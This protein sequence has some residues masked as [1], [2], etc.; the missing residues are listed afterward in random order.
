MIE[1]AQLACAKTRFFATSSSSSSIYRTTFHYYP[2]YDTGRVLAPKFTHEK[3]LID[4]I[5]VGRG[6][7]NVICNEGNWKVL[8]TA[9]RN[10]T[11]PCNYIVCSQTDAGEGK[12]QILR[13]REGEDDATPRNRTIFLVHTHTL[14]AARTR[15]KK[16]H[17]E[18]KCI[19]LGRE[20][21]Q[22]SREMSLSTSKR[23]S[24]AETA[25][26]NNKQTPINWDSMQPGVWLY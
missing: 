20:S 24:F 9:G 15:R 2:W 5:L 17:C 12:G 19:A 25:T 8:L 16:T 10:K 1:T 3:D 18:S 11:T 21:E 14:S 4:V 22:D 26:C 23:D 13:G 6:H 7:C